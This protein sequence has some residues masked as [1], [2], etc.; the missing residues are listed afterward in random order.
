MVRAVTYPFAPLMFNSCLWNVF[1]PAVRAGQGFGCW[2]G[3][4]LRTKEE[5]FRPR[6]QIASSRRVEQVLSCSVLR[7]APG[8]GLVPGEYLWRRERRERDWVFLEP[9]RLRREWGEKKR[10]GPQNH[11]E[12]SLNRRFLGP[13]LEFLIP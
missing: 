2:A 8:M 6:G 10:L 1:R 7:A 12:G 5:Y 13:P 11:R 3:V 4:S 9:R